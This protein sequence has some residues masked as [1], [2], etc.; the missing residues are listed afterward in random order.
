MK[1]GLF[2]LF[3][4]F[5]GTLCADLRFHPTSVGEQILSPFAVGNEA[6][7]RESKRQGTGCLPYP[8]G[9]IGDNCTGFAFKTDY[10]FCLLVV[11]TCDCKLGL[12]CNR[13]GNTSYQTC[14]FF[15]VTVA[16]FSESSF[17]FFATC[18]LDSHATQ[19][20]TV[21]DCVSTDGV[22]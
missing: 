17:Q 1:S 12:V 13:G 15:R 8:P 20:L 19:T 4:W 18:R 7:R 6:V 11:R 5:T 14:N 21:E 3:I 10:P 22:M 16:F 2:A 9:Q